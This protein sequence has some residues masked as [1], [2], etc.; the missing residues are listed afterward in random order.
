MEF[1][2]APQIAEFNISYP[3]SVNKL[4]TQ[5]RHRVTGKPVKILSKA[6]QAFR[7]E[8]TNAAAR[9]G[10]I[11]KKYDGEIWVRIKLYPKDKRRRDIDNAIKQIL[12]S[13]GVSKNSAAIILDD[14]Q[15]SYLEV[16]RAGLDQYG[17]GFC[18]VDIRRGSA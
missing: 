7:S 15:V 18:N 4:Y 10:V 5:G 14:S 17:K 16:V 6:H 3:P 13:L 9:A 2:N 1:N 11:F 8:V 12:D